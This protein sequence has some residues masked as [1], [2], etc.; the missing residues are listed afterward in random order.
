[1]MGREAP[2]LDLFNVSKRETNMTNS[3]DPRRQKNGS[4]PEAEGDLNEERI[5]DAPR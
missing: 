1:M 4:S 3:S 2:S 5:C